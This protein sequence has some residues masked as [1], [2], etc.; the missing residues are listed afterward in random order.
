M[1]NNFSYVGYFNTPIYTL[2]IPEWVKDLNK[3]SD[4]FILE[5]KK[6]DKKIIKDTEKKLKQKVGDLNFVYHSNTLI[7]QKGFEEFQKFIMKTSL[8]ILD[9]MGYNMSERK[10]FLSEFWVQEFSKKGGGSHE[11]HLHY[12]CHMSG[13]YFLKSSDKT[14]FPIFH[15]PRHGK[16]MTHFL[17]KNMDEVTFASEQIHYK[18][19]P[20]NLILF[21]SYLEHSFSKDFGV[22]PFRF[23]HFNIQVLPY[24]V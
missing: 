10:L 22:E 16:N 4:K 23:I 21:P 19:I 17:E 1:K 7:N 6:R 2:H 11:K 12:N 5:A 20:G 8:K 14:S 24:N 9:H 13:F 18:P 15:D 3:A